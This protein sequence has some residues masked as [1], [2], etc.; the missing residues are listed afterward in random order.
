MTLTS[1]DHDPLVLAARVAQAISATY[2]I[3]YAQ[4]AQDLTVVQHSPN[5]SSLL[6]VPEIIGRPIT[7]LL[8]ELAGGAPKFSY[9][10]SQIS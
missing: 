8:W 3:A 2:Q 1:T 9:I 10:L 6:P 7:D 5:F 4:L